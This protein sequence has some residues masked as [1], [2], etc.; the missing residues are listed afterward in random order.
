MLAAS[1]SASHVLR[2]CRFVVKRQKPVA[3]PLKPMPGQAQRDCF[4]IVEKQVARLGGERLLGWA[5]W[6]LPGVFLQAEF[7]AVWRSPS[8]EIVDLTPRPFPCRSSTF[9]RDPHREYEGRQ[10]DNIRQPLVSD[11]DVFHFLLLER[12]MFAIVN[13]G[14]LAYQHAEVQLSGAA[15]AEYEGIEREY[16]RLESVILARY[17]RRP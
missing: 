9:V 8:G 12:R 6:E 16:A 14:D 1:P 7:H 5:I 15:L 13:A 17:L 4:A 11:V 10:V 3:V 2:F